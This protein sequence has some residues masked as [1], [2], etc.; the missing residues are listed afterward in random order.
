MKKIF[1]SVVLLCAAW[2]DAS[3]QNVSGNCYRGFVDAGYDVGIGYFEMSH[4][5]I[6][7]SHGYQFNPY[8]FL[9]A[10]TAFHFMKGYKT[11]GMNIALDE[12]ESKVDIPVFANARVNFMK[13]KVTPFIDGKVGT[14]VTNNGGMYWNLSAGCRIATNQKQ[15]V[16]ISVGYA[17]EK[18][19]FQTVDRFEVGYSMNYIREPRV[20]LSECVTVRV[21]YE[22]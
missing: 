17:S 16:N 4:F 13:K 21:G 6:T 2:L 11:P 7:T 5:S 8:I 9:G 15:A 22:F 19:E 1:I 12:R 10:G 3:A 20:Q 14:Y 18:L